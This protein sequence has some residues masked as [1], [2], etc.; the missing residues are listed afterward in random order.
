MRKCKAGARDG[1]LHVSTRQVIER[2]GGRHGEVER[3]SETY[4]LI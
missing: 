3:P 2:D 4:A 1:S